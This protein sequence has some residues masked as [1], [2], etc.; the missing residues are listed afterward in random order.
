MFPTLNVE[1]ASLTPNGYSV[2]IIDPV[3][4]EYLNRLKYAF[5]TDNQA[6]AFGV[7]VDLEG[8]IKHLDN[9]GCNITGIRKI[10]GDV[11]PNTTFSLPKE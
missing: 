7:F 8:L 5:E 3:E 9:K 6:I 4:I 10:V 11:L 1:L 2:R